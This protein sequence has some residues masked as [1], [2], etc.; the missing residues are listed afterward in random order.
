MKNKILRWVFL[1]LGLVGIYLTFDRFSAAS[2]EMTMVD[3]GIEYSSYSL[4]IVMYVYAF[5]FLTITVL[6][7]IA[8][9]YFGEKKN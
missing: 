3:M 1:I 8:S 2:A 9:I 5:L 4:S 6:F 7:F